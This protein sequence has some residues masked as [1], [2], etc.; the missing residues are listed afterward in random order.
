M[1][2]GIVGEPSSMQFPQACYALVD[3]KAIETVVDS[4]AAYDDFHR[5][6]L[7]GKNVAVLNVRCLTR[8]RS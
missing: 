1:R 5:T 3:G 2:Q 8:L 6:K 7:Q 4:Q